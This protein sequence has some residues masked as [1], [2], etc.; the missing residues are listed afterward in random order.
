[1][2]EN[3]TD[4]SSNETRKGLFGWL[5][6][7]PQCSMARMIVI[8]VLG[9]I[10]IWGGLNTGMEYTNRTEFCLSCHTMRTLT[11]NSRRRCITATAPA[12]A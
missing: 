6:R 4:S 10:L 2:T 7:P 8:G 5:K 11:R 9:G 1:M 12:P 3:S